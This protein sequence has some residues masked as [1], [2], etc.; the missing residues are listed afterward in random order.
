MSREVVYLRVQWHHDRPEDP[1]L[2]YSALDENRWETRKVD[3]WADG[4][5]Q[6]SDSREDEG[7]HSTWLGAVPTPPLAE[8]NDDPQFDGVEISAAEFDEVWL[9]H[10]NA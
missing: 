7:V 2:L 4:T 3:V 6:V 8:I 10:R 5:G 9:K 1:V